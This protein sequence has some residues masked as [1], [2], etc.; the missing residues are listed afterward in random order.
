MR[1]TFINTLIEIAKLDPRIVLL[2]GD[3][4]FMAIEPFIEQFPDRFFNAGVAEQ[5]MIGLATGLAESGFIPF[6]YSI[7]PFAVLRPYEFIRNGPV[8]HQFPVRIVGIGGG[9]EYS[10]NGATHYGLEDIGLMRMQPGMTVIVPADYEQARNALLGSWNLPGPVYFR[11]SKDNQT[12]VPGLSGKFELGR[13]QSI[14]TG[15]DLIMIS[16]GNIA[17]EAVKAADKL[18][19]LGISCAVLSVD[20]LNPSPVA[21]LEEVLSHYKVAISIEAHYVVGGLGSFVSEVIAE[22]GVAC[23]LIR[24]GVKSTPTGITGSQEFMLRSCGLTG[25]QLASTAVEALRKTTVF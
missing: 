12:V 3:L 9:M 6:V 19:T 2:T 5:D 15:T 14:R 8:M 7:V 4:G 10:T 21:D 1:V 20:S 11:L 18:G 17:N 24:C 13:T 16:I 25:D 23:R 22:T